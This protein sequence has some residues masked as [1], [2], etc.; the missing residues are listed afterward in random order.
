MLHLTHSIKLEI[1]MVI[2]IPRITKLPDTTIRMIAAGEVVT[3]PV[4][5]I[6]ELLENSLDAGATN[7]RI[8]I[9][10]G[11][12]KLIDIIDNGH[13][14]ARSDADLLCQRFAT[15][16]LET[17]DDLTRIHTFGFRG[18]A[19]ASISEVAN[20]EVSSHNKTFDDHGWTGKYKSGYLIGTIQEDPISKQGTHIIVRDLFSN[21]LNRKNALQAMFT[22]EKKAITD[23]VMRYAIHH[24]NHVT[25]ILTDGKPPDLICSLAP[26]DLGPSIG[27]FFGLEFE[28]NLTMIV[29]INKEIYDVNV[30]LAISYKRFSGTNQ[31]S[32]FILFVNNRLVECN[33]LK[34]ELEALI[35]QHINVKENSTLVYIDLKVPPNEV[36]VNTHPAKT[37]VTLLNQVEITALI[38]THVRENFLSR[39]QAS[40]LL[41]KRK[42]NLSGYSPSTQKFPEH[43]NIHNF[44]QKLLDTPKTQKP[45]SQSQTQPNYCPTPRPYEL[46]HNDCKQLSLTQMKKSKVWPE[47]I[48]PARSRRDLKLVSLMLLREKVVKSQAP[49]LSKMI[50]HSVFVGT[51]DHKHALIQYDTGLYAINLKEYLIDLHYQFYLFDLGNFPA[52]RILPPGNKIHHFIQITLYDIEKH[53]PKEFESYK[54]KSVDAIMNKLHQ[55]ASLYQDYLNLTF[56]NEEIITIPNIVPQEVPPLVFLGRFLINLVNKVPYDNE[57]DCIRKM[58]LIIADFY[59]EPPANLRNFEVH[60]QY[61]KVVQ[62]KLWLAIKNYQFI[63]KR[64]LKPTYTTKVSDTKVLYK[65]FERC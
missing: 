60:A 22:E 30:E 6:K 15:S 1:N 62:E 56:S 64:L 59:S 23:L 46:V 31:I 48:P 7:I 49:E 28:N 24:R 37:T 19:L 63:S 50:K 45:G 4:N 32:T 27:C 33:C 36:D 3:R 39:A 52:I 18:E 65:V 13:G 12:L 61:Q 44:S 40:Q 57:Y 41:I 8:K 47:V 42:Q 16:K 10:Q 35:S 29:A 38:I 17:S 58:G 9:E 54:Y 20:V 51:F 34:H 14:I 26:I 2:I 21:L 43:V 25:F 11:G 55:H 5:V 53:E